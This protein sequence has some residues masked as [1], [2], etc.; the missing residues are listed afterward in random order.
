MIDSVYLKTALIILGVLVILSNLV[1]FQNLLS[2]L[3]FKSKVKV[4]L[5]GEVR[6]IL[7]AR[8]SVPIPEASLKPTGS[9]LFPYPVIPYPVESVIIIDFQS[10]ETDKFIFTSSIIYLF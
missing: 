3:I 1:D 9:W 5:L 10:A 4:L 8:I 6:T 7:V 2:K